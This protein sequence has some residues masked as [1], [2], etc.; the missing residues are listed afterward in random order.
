VNAFL[1]KQ[2][3]ESVSYATILVFAFGAC[4]YH[5][6]I[7]LNQK[8]LGAET[9]YSHGYLIPFV[10]AYL[11]YQKRAQ[12]KEIQISSSSL[13]LG[14][15]VA[16]LILHLLAE[17]AVINFV[18]P[19]TMI[20]YLL[21]CAM[22]FGGLQLAR[23]LAFPLFYLIFMCPL[24]NQIID[25]IAL[26]L[27]S[28]ATSVA[29]QIIDIIGIPF[30][31][32]GFR[33]HLTSS[34]FIVGTPCNGMRSLISFF[35]LGCLYLPFLRGVWWKK[36]ILLAMIIPLSILLN[37]IRI[38]TL[39]LVANRYGQAAA[40]PESFLHDSSGLMVFVVGLIVLGLFSQII[41]HNHEKSH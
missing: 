29:L 10:S 4:Y 13:G 20:L 24:P 28:M 38:A 6:F 33:I 14:I 30:L 21:G 36:G 31:R 18:S 12:F 26:P 22:Y 5:S 17:L 35:A 19:L 41:D 15:I 25:I 27:K 1:T 34:T 2:R 40:S 8:F 11:I 3:V 32:E 39:L 37:G 9:Y 16:A 7:W 23:G